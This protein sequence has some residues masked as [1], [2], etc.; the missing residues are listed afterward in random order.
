MSGFGWL[1]IG[2]AAGTAHSAFLWHEVQGLP[3]G[4][5]TGTTLARIAVMGLVRIVGVAAV[6][7]LAAQR[8]LPAV[9]LSLLGVL[10]A[11][12]VWLRRCAI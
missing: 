8:G 9:L 4:P 3:V 10:L 7:T 6:L 12:G 5:V 2:V 1:F 11:R